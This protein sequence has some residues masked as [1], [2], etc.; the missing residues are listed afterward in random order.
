MLFV[1][2]EGRRLAASEPLLGAT[3][4]P[5]RTMELITGERFHGELLRAD[6]TAVEFRWHGHTRFRVPAAAVTAIKNPPGVVDVLDEPFGRG[7]WQGEPWSFAPATSPVTSGHAQIWRPSLTPA[8]NGGSAQWRLAFGSE[9]LRIELHAD[10]SVSP[11]VPDRWTVAFRQPVPRFTERVCLRVHWT[12]T[13][14]RVAIGSALWG[15]GTKP[16][17]GLTAVALSADDL[18][19]SSAVRLDDLT[20]RRCGP[21]SPF[22][23]SETPAPLDAVQRSE[24]DIWYGDFLNATAAGVELRGRLDAVT[25]IPWSEFTALRFRSRP[26]PR[27]LLAPVQGRV[28]EFAGPSFWEPWRLDRERWRAAQTSGWFTPPVVDHPVL[29][30]FRLAPGDASV[31]VL[32]GGSTWQ[33]LHPGWI[34]LGNNL[35]EEYRAA[36]PSGTSLSG[37]FELA[38]LPP[39]GAAV[40]LDALG[41]EPCGGNTPPAQPFL[42]EL[43]A[44]G[45]RTALLINGESVGDWNTLLSH[46][47]PVGWPVRLRLPVPRER[48]RVGRNEWEI[49][50]QPLR[51]DPHEF[52][53]CELGRIAWETE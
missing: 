37:T 49:R 5:L 43:R 35:H 11:H 3:P 21:V 30:P 24:G 52:D 33:W 12:E 36:R 48:L 13:E 19:E 14:W 28:M 9:R 6:R 17:G 38:A 25:V 31:R 2:V 16:P 41:L 32:R 1:F 42:E 10:G 44:G 45:L 7:E 29:G 27:E 23:A 47:P 15:Q 34:H 18:H 50:Q 46:R 40:S 39:R 22:P 20:L 53:D 4:R 26:A 8:D 51:S